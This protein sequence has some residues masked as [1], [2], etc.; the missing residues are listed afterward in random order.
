[1]SFFPSKKRISERVPESDSQPS[2]D[3][4]KESL[5]IVEDA[6][7]EQ[8]NQP[9]ESGGNAAAPSN[10]TDENALSENSTVQKPEKQSG[11]DQPPLSTIRNMRELRVKKGEQNLDERKQLLNILKI[12]FTIQMIFMNAIVLLIILWGGLKLSFLRDDME[13]LEAVIDMTKAYITAILVELL[14]GIIFIVH[15]VYSDRSIDGD[16]RANGEESAPEEESR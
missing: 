1:M 15:N 4:Q 6:L 10:E 14:G 7:T 5:S 2:K 11:Q 16:T 8:R 12:L 13:H 9:D 3:A